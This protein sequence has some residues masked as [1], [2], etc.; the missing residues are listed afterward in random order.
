MIT[1]SFFCP[2]CLQEADA[3]A[4]PVDLLFGSRGT[5]AVTCTKCETI[6]NALVEGSEVKLGNVRESDGDSR[7]PGREPT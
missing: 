6:F 4:D 7:E 2:A 3:T 1:F 5:L